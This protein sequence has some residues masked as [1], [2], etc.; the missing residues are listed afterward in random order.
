MGFA[1]FKCRPTAD[2]VTAGL[3][4]MMSAERV[5]LRHLIVDQG[6][7]FNC[8][9]FKNAWCK[10]RN[11]RYRF[12][13]VGRHGSISVVERF[14]RTLKEIL[15]LIV[16]SENQSEFEHAMKCI[17]TW[18]NESRPHMTL[19]GKTA[20]EV[21]YSRPPANEQPRIEPRQNWP[22]GSPCAKPQV[23]IDG[24]PGDPVTIEIDG[25]EGRRHLPII[26]TRHAA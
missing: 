11:I 1:V 17:V 13:A 24:N 8:E 16:V 19:N 18:Y 26:R 14:H 10:A 22:R 21:Y 12:D 7:E 6:P 25:N 15:R 9:H 5:Q 3:D 4:R 20:S 2:E 23:D